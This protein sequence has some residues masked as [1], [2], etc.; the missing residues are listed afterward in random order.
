[1]FGLHDASDLRK[2]LK[3]SGRY[4]PNLQQGVAFGTYARIDANDMQDGTEGACK[5]I[6]EADIPEVTEVTTT[7]LSSIAHLPMTANTF[8]KWKLDIEKSFAMI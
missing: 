3:Y 6:C 5:L 4:R 2:L 8:R 7:C 1:M